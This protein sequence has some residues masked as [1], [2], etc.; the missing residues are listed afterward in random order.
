MFVQPRPPEKPSSGQLSWR[1]QRIRSAGHDRTPPASANGGAAERMYNWCF[2]A[3]CKSSRYF[4]SLK[5]SCFVNIAQRSFL[6]DCPCYRSN[7]ER[8]AFRLDPVVRDTINGR[9]SS[10]P[11]ASYI[12]FI[13]VK[14]A[15]I[16]NIFTAAPRVA[17]LGFYDG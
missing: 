11:I 8:P 3:N 14:A 2:A 17:I 9:P 1:K 5:L 12:R 15:E 13:S 10:Q 7:A 6:C 16:L 4:R